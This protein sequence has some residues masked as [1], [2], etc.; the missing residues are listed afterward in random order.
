MRKVSLYIASSLDGYIAK[1]DG[2]V[3]W[4]DD[5]PNP[6]EPD[7][8]Y[9]DFIEN[10]DA[11]LFGGKTYRQVLTFDDWPYEGREAFVFSRSPV[12]T[13]DDKV[14]F[15]SGDIVHFVTE[16][17]AKPGKTIWLVGGGEVNSLMLQNHLIDEIIL[18][19]VPIILGEGVPLFSRGK[20]EKQMTLRQHRIFKNGMVQLT[21]ARQKPIS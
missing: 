14:T 5:F 8:G 13:H 12:V 19:L 3:D 6:D 20:L 10:V 16:L 17:K 9:F 7:M 4:L 1:A 15:I 2:S 18:T 21:Y 11:L